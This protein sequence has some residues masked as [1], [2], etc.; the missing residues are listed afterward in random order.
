MQNDPATE[1]N[2]LCSINKFMLCEF[3]LINI[4]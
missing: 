3:N 2:G 1:E 4:T